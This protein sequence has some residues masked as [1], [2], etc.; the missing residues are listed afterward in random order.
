MG[1]LRDPALDLMVPDESMN[2]EAPINKLP[3]EVLAEIFDCL[4]DGPV[5]ES[6]PRRANVKVVKVPAR[7]SVVSPVCRRWRRVMC[8]TPYLWRNIF[9]H[10]RRHW[11]ILC[12][13]RCASSP[14]N[15][16]FRHFLCEETGRMLSINNWV[17]KI[18]S[19]SLGALEGQWP[20]LVLTLLQLQNMPVLEKLHLQFSKGDLETCHLEFIPPVSLDADRFPNLHELSIDGFSLPS[21]LSTYPPLRNLYVHTRSR[22]VFLDEFLHIVDVMRDLEVLSY[23]I[24]VTSSSI[25]RHATGQIYARE[26]TLPKLHTLQLT[27]GSYAF[28]TE[29]LARI[30]IPAAKFVT[31]RVSG[32]GPRMNE[33]T[34]SGY[35][36][37]DT[38]SILPMLDNVTSVETLSSQRSYGIR[39]H[40][41]LQTIDLRRNH[42]LDDSNGGL[43]RCLTD[44]VRLF[45]SAPL[46]T[47]S[48]REYQ[49]NVPSSV[50]EDVFSHF[51]LLESIFIDRTSFVG[52]NSAH[53]FWRALGPML[54]SNALHSPGPLPCPLPR[55]RTVTVS[56]AYIAPILG[57]EPWA[58]PNALHARARR[59]YQLP[60]LKV[61]CVVEGNYPGPESDPVYLKHL[62]DSVGELELVRERPNHDRTA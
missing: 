48:I 36:P 49:G 46:I 7:S 40:G 2:A 60:R 55:L 13:T 61:G 14:T 53:P 27:I 56:R 9:V 5:L 20:F 16:F 19:L 50:W 31:I 51:P 11:L 22:V 43:R 15:I 62:E 38:S 18:H 52:E 23:H 6:I 8:C 41:P 32:N 1:N 21:D 4:P 39:A 34:I 3:E 54:P 26:I 25:T 33:D 44:L 17:S 12:L 30:R 59:G 29:L 24:T 45:R 57:V 37:L 28:A 58:M 47:L 42:P 35:L 10:S